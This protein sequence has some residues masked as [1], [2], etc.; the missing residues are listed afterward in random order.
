MKAFLKVNLGKERVKR[1]TI[2]I[3]L[4]ILFFAG[5]FIASALKIGFVMAF[6]IWVIALALTIIFILIIRLILDNYA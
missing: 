4:L 1:K 6:L 5:L 2:G 3:I